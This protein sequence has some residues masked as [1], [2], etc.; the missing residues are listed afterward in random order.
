MLCL[1]RTTAAATP[2]EATRFIIF[3]ARFFWSVGGATVV[4]VVGHRG[5][6]GATTILFLSALG[7]GRS[8]PPAIAISNGY[9]ALLCAT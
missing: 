2:A 8:C 9:L 6:I 3:V 5:G 7:G 1:P 4:I